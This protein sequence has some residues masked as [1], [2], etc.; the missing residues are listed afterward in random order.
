MTDPIVFS[1]IPNQL[2]LVDWGEAGMKTH[3]NS[4]HKCNEICEYVTSGG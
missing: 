2:G 4:A 1:K 3:M